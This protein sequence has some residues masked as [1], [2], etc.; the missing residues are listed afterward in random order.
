MPLFPYRAPWRNTGYQIWGRNVKDEP[1][2]VVYITEQRHKMTRSRLSY[3]EV[4]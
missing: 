3:S 4:D 2:T 1:E